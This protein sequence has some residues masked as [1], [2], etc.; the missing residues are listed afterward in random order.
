MMKNPKLLI[1]TIFM[2][3]LFF[4]GIFGPYLPFVDKDL[5]M[6]GSRVIDGDIKLPPFPPSIENLFGTDRKGIDLLSRIILG[7]REVLIVLF[8]VVLLRYLVAIPLGVFSLYSRGVKWVQDFL[9]KFL[10]FVPPVF[11]VILIVNMPILVYSEHRYY[12]VIGIIALLEAG[13]AAEKIHLQVQS[14]SQ[15]PYIEAAITTGSGPVTLFKRYYVPALI[16]ELIVSVFLE[17]GRTMFLIGQLGIVK[18]YL[19]HKLQVIEA[20]TSIVVEVQNTSNAW[21]LL[22]SDILQDIFVYPWIPFVACV[23]ITIVILGFFTLAD[24]LR[25]HF[26]KGYEYL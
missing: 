18:I 25:K 12:I 19:S 24:G 8:S 3:A 2:I 22:F 6:V 10:S 11:M 7:T 21:P 20:Q 9:N 1:G 16:P 13:R 4:F 15:K 17:L 14:I 26:Q 5:S 23:I